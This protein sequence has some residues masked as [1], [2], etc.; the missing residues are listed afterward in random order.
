MTAEARERPQPALLLRWLPPLAIAMVFLV[1]DSRRLWAPFGPSHDGFNAALFMTGGRAIVEEGLIASELGATS[2]TPSGDRVVYAHHPPLIYIASALAYT[3]PGPVEARAR[4]PAVVAALS[5][6]FLTVI[7]LQRCG[8]A[9][10]PAAMG[11]LLAF[12]TPMFLVFGAVT[13]PDALGLVPMTG[14][15]LLWQ[16]LREGTQVRGWA[17]GSVAAAGALTSWHVCLFAALLGAALLVERRPAAAVAVLLGATA[18]AVLTSLWML[19]AYQGDIS[20]F[21]H[22][23]LLRAGVGG[24][25]RVGTLQMVGQQIHYLRDLFPVGRGLVVVVAGSGL[26]DRRTRPL[27]AVSLGTVLAYTLVF[28]NGAYDHSYWLYPVLLPLALGAAV[29]AAAAS[30]WLAS[31]RLP[32][33]A[34]TALGGTL[35]LA[36]ALGIRRVSD[37]QLQDAIGAAVGAQARDIAWPEGQRYAYHTLGG[38][39]STDLLP[40]LRFYARREPFGVDGP[41]SVPR[42]QVV[43]RMVDG[44]LRVEPGERWP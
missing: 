24:Q 38:R 33:L 23:A 17:L 36:V 13:E 28:K 9:S 21:F 39:G 1:H 6:L 32:R 26:L 44:R 35:T 41:A 2:Q 15:T 25:N 3:L 5:T 7:L 12:G 34:P 10:G 14:L 43:L 31:S 8:V 40:W 18:G 37:E 27:V 42:G 11:L 19:W 4:L 16:R 30:R 29:V 22:R 20:G